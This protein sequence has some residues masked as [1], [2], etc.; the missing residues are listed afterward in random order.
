MANEYRWNQEDAR[1]ATEAGYMPLKE[2]LE[3]CSENGWHPK[4]SNSPPPPPDQTK[5][6][7]SQR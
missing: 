2:Y 1:A 7:P 6:V 5:A 4:T 3:L